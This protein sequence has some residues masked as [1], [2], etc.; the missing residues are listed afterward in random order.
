M[1]PTPSDGGD[2][3]QTP[4]G[5]DLP[6]AGSEHA[7]ATGV[8]VTI[9]D[10][11]RAKRAGEPLVMVTAYDHPSARLAEQA[12]V[13]LIL[14]GDSAAM[15]VLGHDTTNAVTMDEMVVFTRAVTRTVRRPFVVADMPFMSF[16]PSNDVALAN[17]GRFVREGR[18]DAVK[19][20]GGGT[21]VDRVH[22]LSDAGIAVFAHLGLTP[23]SATL[24]GGYRAQA[25]SHE[26]ALALLDD[27]L[28]LEQAGAVCIVLEAIPAQIAG[29]VTRA[30]HV[31]T[32]GIGA[33]ARTDG[34]VLVFHDLLGI[35]PGRLPRFVRRYAEIGTEIEGAIA[36]YA[37]EVRARTFPAPEHTY[38][39]PSEELAAFEAASRARVHAGDT[40][41][42]RP[43]G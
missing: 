6:G 7:K 34:Q 29:A 5:S 25:R 32:I 30:V 21:T 3:T 19:V 8:K 11:H 15:V 31:P 9:G 18:A 14:V 40:A 2:P 22:A 10:L 26:Q 17:A 37:G 38:S 20:E 35:T 28:A 27:A 16:Q 39:I 41:T 4:Y 13:D 42:R 23:Q 43:R 33:G 36:A 12:G 1:T 24:L